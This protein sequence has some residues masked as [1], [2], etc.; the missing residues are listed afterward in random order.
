MIAYLNLKMRLKN[1]AK[2][3]KNLENVLSSVVFYLFDTSK[4]HNV[5]DFI[6]YPWQQGAYLYDA[7]YTKKKKWLPV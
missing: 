1:N 4:Y 2:L 6:F 7:K 5:G 3:K